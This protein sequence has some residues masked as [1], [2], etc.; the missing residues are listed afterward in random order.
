MGK[1]KRTKLGNYISHPLMT[2]KVAKYIFLCSHSTYQSEAGA[3]MK[4]FAVEYETGNLFD[5][6][7]L[8][9]SHSADDSAS[10]GVI[11]SA[12]RAVDRNCGFHSYLQNAQYGYDYGTCESMDF[13]YRFCSKTVTFEASSTTTSTLLLLF[14]LVQFGSIVCHWP[15]LSVGEDGRD[16][17]RGG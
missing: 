10:S 17:I 9:T 1:F 12:R 2:L 4:L 7:Y 15:F 5:F 6:F 3:R 16:L 11:N 13:G 14:A 8:Q